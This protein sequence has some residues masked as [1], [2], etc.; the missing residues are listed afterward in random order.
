MAASIFSLYGEIFVEN[1]DA[2]SKITQTENKGKGLASKLGSAFKSVG[3]AIAGVAT[4]AGAAFVSLT[5]DAL[6]AAGELE[7]NVGGSE[8]VF[9][10]YA[11]QMQATASTA[12]SKMGLSASDF[13][14]TA[15]KMGALFQG[16]G[17]TVEESAN[18]SAEAMQRAADVASIM[19]ID[20]GSAMEAVAGAAKG[21]FTMMDNLGVSMNAASLEAYRLEKGMTTAYNK[22]SQQEKVALAMEMFMEKTAYATGNYAKENET[23]SG[24]LNTAKAAFSN[25]LAGTGSAKDVV[26]SLTNATKVVGKNLMEIIPSLAEGLIEIGTQLLPEV[27]PIASSLINE[28]GTAIITN[29]PQLLDA[30]IA[31][32]GAI[33]EFVFDNLPLL[34]DTAVEIIL[35]F[36]QGISEALPQLI[37]AIVELMIQITTTLLENVELLTEAATQLITGLAIGLIQAL[38]VLIQA[39]PELIV[40]LSGAI[41]EGVGQIMSAGIELMDGLLTGIKNGF[42]SLMTSMSGFVTT[43]IIQP[44]KNK[45]GEFQSIGRQ[46]IDNMLQGL[47]SAWENVKNWFNNAWNSLF[48]NRNVNVGA[49][50]NEYA[51]GLDYVPYDEFPAFLHEGEAVLTK[52]EANRWRAGELDGGGS[53]NGGIVINQYIETVPQTPVDFA[54]A[55]A[56]YFEQARWALS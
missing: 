50:V 15:N 8:Q 47:K 17:F 21:N 16:S 24:S 52:E 6:N 40:A 43:Y 55:T 18:L 12:F 44:I 53:G 5:K 54:D 14:A 3:V 26:S 45:F 56:A 31:L 19:G 51:T 39:A 25:F 7:Q 34:T 48:A 29:L 22:M 9:K 23:L 37:P 32:V 27:I 20:V 38:P 10:Q 41:V 28:F 1:Q 33:G 30:A 42:A 35:E 46:V 4:A 36:A 11:E 49:S 13:L 2:I